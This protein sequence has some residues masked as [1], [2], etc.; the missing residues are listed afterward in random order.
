MELKE[1][2]LKIYNEKGNGNESLLEAGKIIAEEVSKAIGVKSDE[3]AIIL[4]TTT[5]N[6][7]K[8]IY[9]PPLFESNSA[10]PADYKNSFASSVFKTMKGKVDN[11]I[12]E[13]K[14]LKFYENVKGLETS[15][16]PI[17]KMIG[18][19]IVYESKPIGVIE[20]SRKGVNPDA[21]GP[22]FTAED[23]QKL[24]ALCKEFASILYSMIPNPFF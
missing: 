19:P 1:K 5:G 24:V 12:Y 18:V 11:K 20:A 7:L 3:V 22:N 13:M 21:S 14:H 15:G 16:V 2:L 9:P 17:Q 4:A 6:T 10:F 23:G 8:F